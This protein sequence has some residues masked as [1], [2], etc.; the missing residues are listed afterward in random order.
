MREQIRFH[1]VAFLSAV[2]DLEAAETAV[3]IT[4]LARMWADRG[5]LQQDERLNAR[6][7]GMRPSR[8]RKVFA[9]LCAMKFFDL[10]DGRIFMGQRSLSMMSRVAITN[11]VRKRVLARAPACV[12]CGNPEGPFEVDHVFPAAQ[13]G[14]NH[15]DNLAVACVPCNRE[16]RAMTVQ[17]WLGH[18][19]E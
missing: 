13:G 7:C 16:K 14:T 4:M 8:Y 3:L 9:K 15:R 18:E 6:Y 12:Y 1:P 11:E 19:Q 17:E 2:I 5:F 10:R